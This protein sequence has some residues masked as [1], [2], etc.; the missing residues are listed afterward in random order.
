MEIQQGGL[1]LQE[2]LIKRLGD[3]SLIQLVA[4]R[5]V[6]LGYKLTHHD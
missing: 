6:E 5:N 2:G 4:V 3:Q 1:N